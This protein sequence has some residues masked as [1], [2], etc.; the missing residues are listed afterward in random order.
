MYQKI[1]GCLWTCT[2]SNFYTDRFLVDMPDSL[3]WEFLVMASFLFDFDGLMHCL[4]AIGI[5]IE[6]STSSPF[7]MNRPGDKAE[8]IECF[9]MLK[10]N[11]QLVYTF[12]FSHFN[13]LEIQLRSQQNI[14]Y[15]RTVNTNHDK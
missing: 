7:A 2:D 6:I 13:A 10:V 15:T 5:L 9:A 14:V 8:F 12:H 1:R 11:I 4:F 3:F